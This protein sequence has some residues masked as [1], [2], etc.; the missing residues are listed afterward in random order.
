MNLIELAESDKQN[1]NRFVAQAPSGSFLQSWEWGEWQ[2]RLGRE[3][4]RYLAKDEQGNAVV[5]LQLIKMPLPFGKY[6]LY[7]PYGPVLAG[8]ESAS[9][10][11]N[12]QTIFNE[13]ISKF[14]QSVFI[15]IE[16]KDK[17]LLTT[18]YSLLAK[19]PNIQPAITMLVDLNKSEEE[20]LSGMHP[21]TRYNIKI[22]QKHGVV[23]QS[24]LVAAPKYGLYIEEAINLFLDT[25]KRQN[26]RGHNPAYYKNFIDFFA[27]RNKEN[28]LRLTI[29][30]AIYNRKL[31]A[32]GA[33]VDF[34]PTR[35]YLYGGSSHEDRNVMAPYLMHWQAMLDA[36]AAGLKFYDLGGSEVSNGGERGFTRFKQGFG[37]RV[38]N[39]AG[40]YDYVVKSF[41]YTLYKGLRAVN[42][43]SKKLWKN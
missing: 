16:P 11:F 7:C 39:Y 4:F 40:A 9:G 36:K 35:M 14:P 27:M 10:G 8:G 6:Y 17:G 18:S 21:K 34:G 20:L 25:Q 28:D 32:C 33:I 12:F 3:V 15:R 1:Y 2:V 29:Y 19:S 30:K 37:G 13:I 24:E 31:L 26:Y 41:I 42:R 5:T 22:A 38:E 23:V 43:F